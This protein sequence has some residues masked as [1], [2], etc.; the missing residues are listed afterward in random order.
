MPLPDPELLNKFIRKECNPVELKMVIEWLQETAEDDRN[1]GIEH[2]VSVRRPIVTAC[3]I[4]ALVIVTWVFFF[5]RKGKSRTVHQQA[6]P[7]LLI[8]VDNFLHV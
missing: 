3:I 7:A 2:P 6:I 8:N 5:F 4:A 1:Q